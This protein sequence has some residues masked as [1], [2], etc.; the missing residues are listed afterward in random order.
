MEAKM[1][2]DSSAPLRELRPLSAFR[3]RAPV[4]A[5]VPE[6]TLVVEEGGRTTARRPQNHHTRPRQQPGRLEPP[7]GEARGGGATLTGRVPVP[8]LRSR[9]APDGRRLPG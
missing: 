9:A 4:E 3:G 1:R 6:P 7:S 5:R 2:R 8:M